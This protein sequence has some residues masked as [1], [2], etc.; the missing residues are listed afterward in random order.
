MNTLSTCATHNYTEWRQA[1]ER[2]ISESKQMRSFYWLVDPCSHEDLPGL[3]WQFDQQPIVSPLYVNT[4][5]QEAINSG[6]FM[7][8]YHQDSYFSQW[9]LNELKN[10]A[11][12]CMIEIESEKLNIAFEHL[13]NMLECLDSNGKHSIFRFY[14]PRIIYAITTY[15]DKNIS[16]RILGP[17]LKLYAWEPGRSTHV[18]LGAG[19]DTGMRGNE[20][21]H[22]EQY[23]FAHI[24]NEVQL[25]TLIGNLWNGYAI[26]DLNLREAYVVFEK[27][28]QFISSYG[29]HDRFSITF[30]CCVAADQGDSVWRRPDVI[31]VFEQRPQ[32]ASIE[33]LFEFI[34]L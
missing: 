2:H 16:D 12:G 17:I 32:N 4:Y 24:W 31:K 33:E 3:I 9:M 15:K 18:A 19:F 20:L 14:D 29:Y 25:H 7:V 34:D 23:F 22:Y 28:F 6:P 26:C 30:A 5:K 1:L 10:A 8:Q 11:L 21:E 13:Q 27:T